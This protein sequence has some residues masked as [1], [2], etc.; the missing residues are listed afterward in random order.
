MSSPSYEFSALISNAIWTAPFK[1][2]RFPIFVLSN[3]IRSPWRS[4]DWPVLGLR[5]ILRSMLR[6]LKGIILPVA[7]LWVLL[8]QLACFFPET[9]MTQEEHECCRQMG[10]D[11]DQA[12]MREHRCC[13]YEVKLERALT[14]PPHRDELSAFGATEHPTNFENASGSHLPEIQERFDAAPPFHRPP[15]TSAPSIFILRI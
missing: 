12:T 14:A 15:L 6:R 1:G 5:S 4:C 9:Q 13:T 3:R 2:M 11:C 10:R 8:P 7:L